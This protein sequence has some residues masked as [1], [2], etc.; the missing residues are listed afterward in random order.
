M[1]AKSG[2]FSLS[3]DITRS[4]PVLC[5]EYY[6][7]DGIL[8]PRFSQSRA[9]CKFLAFYDP[10]PVSNIPRGVLGTRVNPDSKILGYM[11]T[12]PKFES[13]LLKTNKDVRSSAKSRN[14]TDVYVM[15]RGGKSIPPLTIDVFE[16]RTFTFYKRPTKD[17]RPQIKTKTVSNLSQLYLFVATYFNTLSILC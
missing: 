4:N 7:Q 6:V 10:F 16:R 12:G 11:W 13:D 17:S 9:R 14:F 5:R 2:K 1:D 3:G 15:G 8:V